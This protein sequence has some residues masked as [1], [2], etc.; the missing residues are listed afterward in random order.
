M[1]AAMAPAAADTLINYFNDTNTTPGDYDLILTGDLGDVG[2]KSLYDLLM[3]DNID[4]KNR[5][6]DCG[7]MIY[8]REKQ[9]V[10]S[11][12]SGC[13]CAGSVL[14]SKILTELKNHRLNNILFM[15]TGALM[16]PTTC[17]QGQSIPSVA[18]LLNIK[19]KN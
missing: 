3:L 1:G 11:G 14:C 8:D 17:G 7:L 6:N 4:I 10:H 15:A 2:S 16:S 18:H 5:H 9:D 13:G 19:N 12:G